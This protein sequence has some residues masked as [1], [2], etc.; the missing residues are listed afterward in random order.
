[1]AGRRK[2][3]RSI[4]RRDAR[5]AAYRKPYFAGP[6][7]ED[8][9]IRPPLAAYSG[10]LFLQVLNSHLFVR[11]LQAVQGRQTRPYLPAPPASP[12]VLRLLL[13]RWAPANLPH[14]W[15]DRTRQYNV[16]SLSCRE[17]IR[18]TAAASK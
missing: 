7:Q 10:F 4:G 3:K 9:R 14:A 13:H 8:M 16:P 15:H 2:T 18:A 1:M 11:E 17:V 12:D 6:R 5:T